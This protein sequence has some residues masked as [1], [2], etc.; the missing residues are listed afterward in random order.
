MEIE[1]L[2]SEAALNERIA[3][4]VAETLRDKPDASLVFPLGATPLGMFRVVVRRVQAGEMDLSRVRFIELDDYLGIALDDARNLYNW[5]E[6][7]L[8]IPAGIQPA[9][10]VRFNT[11]TS[12][13]AAEAARVEAIAQAQ[14]IDLAILGIGMNG[15]LGFNEP[16]T[17]FDSPTQVIDLTPE[18]V[19]SNAPYW[20]GEDRVPRRALTLGLGTL[21]QAKVVVLMVN[22][23][24]KAD[25]LAQ[26]M[27]SEPTPA[28]PATVL[29]N[30]PNARVLADAAAAAAQK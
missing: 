20:G 4:I 19:A 24:R 26:V 28:L 2:E 12:D 21:M 25:I 17:A 6:R 3:D 23:Q 16:G 9:Q 13:P 30:H 10:V 27:A 14:G 5:F 29:K 18:S 1:I 22:G 8:M 15:H 11:D 7:E